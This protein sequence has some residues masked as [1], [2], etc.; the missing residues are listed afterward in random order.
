V[1][2]DDSVFNITVQDGSHMIQNLVELLFLVVIHYCKCTL[3]VYIGNV[4]LEKLHPLNNCV[5]L[6]A[7]DCLPSISAGKSIYL[8]N[9]R[10]LIKSPC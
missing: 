4:Q 3:H 7:I 5:L 8:Q 2:M 1:L 10:S 9:E 6:L